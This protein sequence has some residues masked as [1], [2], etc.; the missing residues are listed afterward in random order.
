[1]EMLDLSDIMSHSLCLLLG[2][3]GKANL[4]T[5]MSQ[6]IDEPV[7]SFLHMGSQGSAIGKEHLSEHVQVGFR[8]GSE[9][10]ETEQLLSI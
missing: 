10:E 9:T 3:N 4:L 8:L 2:V 7:T 6:T 1:M 5:G